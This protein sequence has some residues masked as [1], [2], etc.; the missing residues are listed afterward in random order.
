MATQ[1]ETFAELLGYS[2]GYATSIIATS[3]QAAQVGGPAV[4]SETSCSEYDDEVF[5]DTLVQFTDGSRWLIQ[6]PLS[7][8]KLQQTHSP[9]EARQVF[10]AQCLEDPMNK[11]EHNQQAVVKIKFQ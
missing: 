2:R 11:H 7:N 4:S 8:L 10:T 6:K 1:T 9:C 5:K 3:N